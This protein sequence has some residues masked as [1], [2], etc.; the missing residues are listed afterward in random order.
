M[1][2]RLIFASVL[3]VSLSLFLSL[4]LATQG[5]E[6]VQASTSPDTISA[7]PSPPDLPPLFEQYFSTTHSIPSAKATI[8]ILEQQGNRLGVG[9]SVVLAVRI[10]PRSPPTSTINWMVLSG[11]GDFTPLSELEDT[12]RFTLLTP[13]PISHDTSG[14]VVG[15]G[16]WA[17]GSYVSD[18]ISIPLDK[19][20]FSRPYI[21]NFTLHSGNKPF[22]EPGDI[23]TVSLEHALPPSYTLVYEQIV[24]STIFTDIETFEP[25]WF[26]AVAIYRDP[27]E[28]LVLDSFFEPFALPFSKDRDNNDIPDLVDQEYA[29]I[30]ALKQK[31]APIPPPNDP[32]RALKVLL[33]NMIGTSLWPFPELTFDAN[34]EPSTFGYYQWNGSKVND[35]Q[36]CPDAFVTPLQFWV[37]FCH[38]MKHWWDEK[39]VGIHQDHKEVEKFG[40]RCGTMFW[41]SWTDLDRTIYE[42][43]DPPIEPPLTLDVPWGSQVEWEITLKNES[44]SFALENPQ[45]RLK[46][47]MA[48]N[49]QYVT[50]DILGG[51]I[52]VGADGLVSTV[53]IGDDVQLIPVGQGRPDAIVIHPGPNGVL[54]TPPGG[55]DTIFPSEDRVTSGANGIIETAA[56]GDDI[57]VIPKGL[58][59]TST[60][61]MPMAIGAGPDGIVNSTPSGDDQLI[62]PPNLPIRNLQFTTPTSIPAKG[63][64]TATVSFAVARRMP[65]NAWSTGVILMVLE[66]TGERGGETYQDTIEVA[67]LMPPKTY[68]PA[69]IK[70]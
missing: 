8:V 3:V 56:Q 46:T 65:G 38:E 23:V 50:G 24:P 6:P 26:G 64:G 42:Q 39:I 32:W 55:D 45:I 57:Q 69:V 29:K 25:V 40:W 9:N 7:P 53:A 35:L 44:E 47:L 17:G 59:Y 13:G 60:T 12:V 58:G 28:Q 14:V 54:D 18:M 61:F 20:N 52:S 19:I 49:G 34:C 4:I 31:P 66:L 67:L 27:N 41:P 16:F 70:E 22:P 21:R 2:A 62:P 68:L 36:F 43:M 63:E 51:G 15:V 48:S 11:A 1:R 37:T 10:S 30:L 5:A 33:G